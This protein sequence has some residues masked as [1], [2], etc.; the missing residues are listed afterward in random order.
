MGAKSNMQKSKQAHGVK[1]KVPL[2]RVAIVD[3]DPDLLTFFNDL[4]DTGRFAL[5]GAYSN[6]GDALE[7]VLKMAS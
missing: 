7:R 2:P 4:A 3:D 5:A 1:A 6:A